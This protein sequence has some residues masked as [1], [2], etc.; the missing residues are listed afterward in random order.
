MQSFLRESAEN[1]ESGLSNGGPGGGG[2][3]GGGGEG[4]GDQ[5]VGYRV[6]DRDDDDVDEFGERNLLLP[7]NHKEMKKKRFKDKCKRW[8]STTRVAALALLLLLAIVSP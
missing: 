6:M 5:Q 4:E 7:Y 3:G 1:R 2:G 8:M